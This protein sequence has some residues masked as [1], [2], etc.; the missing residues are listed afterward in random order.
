MTVNKTALSAWGVFL[1]LIACFIIGEYHFIL[2]HTG[3]IQVR[4]SLQKKAF[5]DYTALKLNESE[6]LR[7]LDTKP[8]TLAYATCAPVKRLQ[9]V[10]EQSVTVEPL[11]QKKRKAQTK[12]IT[13][14]RKRKRPLLR[15]HTE[16]VSVTTPVVPAN[17]VRRRRGRVYREQSY[18]EVP[19]KAL[20][21]RKRVS[22]CVTIKPAT[23]QAAWM[24][25]QRE[26]LF[27][28]PVQPADFWISSL[29]GPRRKPSGVW[30]FHAGIDMAAPRGT[31]VFA[32]AS[33][34][35]VEAAYS[36][37]YGNYIMIAH[38]RKFKTRYAHLD[39]ILVRVGQK[40]SSDDCI[41]R[42]GATGF[43]RKSRRGGSAA[44]LHFEVYMKGKAV[45]PFY[46]L[47]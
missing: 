18:E 44:H 13:R 2:C 46:F 23:A 22:S 1:F 12:K 21:T 35:I 10:E 3:T 4:S 27:S 45:N 47:A 31:P 15:T 42:V 9:T 38:N 26:P 33:G 6:Q 8:L 39:K 41:G 40:V 28:W 11:A 43:V 24:Q 5:S 29:F 36:P 32:A 20:P 14:G 34:I 7:F 37:G 30:G 16:K 17:R 19:R 25:L